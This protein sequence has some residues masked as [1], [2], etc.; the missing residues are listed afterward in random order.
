MVPFMTILC[1]NCKY[2]YAGIVNISSIN[3][4]T[5][6]ILFMSSVSSET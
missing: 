4:F 1:W 6:L 3:A 5:L 2:F